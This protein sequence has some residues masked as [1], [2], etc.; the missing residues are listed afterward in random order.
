MHAY[1]ACVQPVLEAGLVDS[2][3]DES[4][5]DVLRQGGQQ[6]Q[7]QAHTQH[8][9]QTREM[10]DAHL[11]CLTWEHTEILSLS[12]VNLRYHYI[13]LSREYII[14]RVHYRHCPLSLQ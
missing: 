2:R 8:Q 12:Y 4:I 9:K 1:L 5:D 10:L 13:S 6:R 3:D 14:T 11:Q 7:N